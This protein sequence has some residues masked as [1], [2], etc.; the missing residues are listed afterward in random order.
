MMK[1]DMISCIEGNIKKC[2]KTAH[3]APISKALFGAHVGMTQTQL[4]SVSISFCLKIFPGLQISILS[5]LILSTLGNISFIILE[6][7]FK[8][9]IFS[10]FFRIPSSI[11]RLILCIFRVFFVLEKNWLSSTI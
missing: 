1:M 3:K 11:S 9:Q 2:I 6:G 5:Y 4:P 8:H 10:R 7:F